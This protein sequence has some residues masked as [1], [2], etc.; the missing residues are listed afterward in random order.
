MDGEHH[1]GPQHPRRT[2][3]VLG[4]LRPHEVMVL[5]YGTY[6]G[7]IYLVAPPPSALVETAGTTYTRVWAAGLV[8]SGVTGLASLLRRLSLPFRLQIEQGAMLMGAGALLLVTFAAWRLPGRGWFT[9]GLAGAWA[10]ANV[11]RMI[12]IR[13]ELKKIT[14]PNE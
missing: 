9:I 11:I 12:Q 13:R 10:V 3:V 14:R 5:V 1:G 4:S 7:T 8:L 2:V 6:A